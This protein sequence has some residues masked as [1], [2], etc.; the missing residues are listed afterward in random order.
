M[1]GESSGGFSTPYFA[2]KS[3]GFI[4]KAASTVSTYRNKQQDKVTL[5]NSLDTDDCH[6]QD[7]EHRKTEKGQNLKN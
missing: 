3:S 1:F 5:D 7:D 2:L 6:K 4:E